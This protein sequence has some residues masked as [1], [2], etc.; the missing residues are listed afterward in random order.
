[1]TTKLAAPQDLSEKQ[2]NRM[3]RLME[4]HYDGVTE[5]AFYRDLQ[6]KDRVILLEEEGEIIGFS[7]QKIFRHGE[8]RILF[9]G[10]T[11]IH[12]N[13]WGTQ[14]LSQAFARH[15]FDDEEGPLYWFLI[16]K[17]YK[18]YKYLPTFFREFYPR[19]DQPT[20]PEMKE[21]LDALG[22][23]LY[24]DAYDKETGVVAYPVA[25][26]RLKKEL[27]EISVRPND[28]HYAFFVEANPGY[29][30]GHDLACITLLTRS[31]VRK[32]AE[33][34]LFGKNP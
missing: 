11:I 20:P 5:T 6:D 18:T 10:D 7:T 32:G 34:I 1:M 12:R 2:I 23:Q 28:P 33:R 14:Q 13:H 22:T 21:L 9:S 19:Y 4:E 31:N 16:S 17:G 3:F 8:Y 15:F 26:D 24:P 25:K 29:T 30:R 27:Q